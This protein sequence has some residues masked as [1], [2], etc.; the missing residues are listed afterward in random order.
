M[1]PNA[2]CLHRTLFVKMP[3]L[4]VVILASLDEQLC[5]FNVVLLSDVGT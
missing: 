4:D 3:N 2:L 5:G 1:Y